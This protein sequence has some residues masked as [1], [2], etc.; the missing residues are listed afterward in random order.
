[1]P[2]LGLYAMMKYG[3]VYARG[4]FVYAMRRGFTLIEILCVVT[5]LGIAATA[6][7]PMINNGY[8]DVKL[9][10]AGRSVMADLFYAQNYAITTQKEVYI[11][12]TAASPTIGGKY[13]FETRSGTVV[14]TLIRPG[15]TTFIVNLGKVTGTP[16]GTFVADA[17]L[18][19]VNPVTVSGSQATLKTIGFDTLGQPFNGTIASLA[20][21]PTL[22]PLLSPDGKITMTL[23]IE[24]FTGEITVQ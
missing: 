4:C 8:A 3:E 23:S 16:S 19:T 7:I 22:L 21:G 17:K 20:S 13:T 9:T 6:A 18:D 15:G 11:V 10:A 14:T 12:F 5:I 1:M 24:P 2:Q